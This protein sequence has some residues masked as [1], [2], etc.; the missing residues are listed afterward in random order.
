[1]A[2]QAQ[3]TIDENSFGAGDQKE[4]SGGAAPC[5]DVNLR[6]SYN[7]ADGVP[8]VASTVTEAVV[9]RT[10]TSWLHMSRSNSSDM[11]MPTYLVQLE[12]ST[13]PRISAWRFYIGEERHT[14]NHGKYFHLLVHFL[15]DRKE[16]L[17]RIRAESF[18][19]AAAE[20]R[21]D[22]KKAKCLAIKAFED[23][24]PATASLFSRPGDPVAAPE[25]AALVA[26]SADG[27]LGSTGVG[28]DVDDQHQTLTT[29]ESQQVLCDQ[30]CALIR[31]A[32]FEA[33]GPQE[34]ASLF[35][36]CA[37]AAEMMDA[38]QLAAPTS[39]EECGQQGTGE[40]EEMEEEEV[41]LELEDEDA[42]LDAEM[43]Q[44]QGQDQHQRASVCRQPGR[45]SY[46]SSVS[47]KRARTLRT[48]SSTNAFHMK[49]SLTRADLAVRK[50]VPTDTEELMRAIAD[51]DFGV[52]DS[53]L[54]MLATPAMTA[55]NRV[56]S[57]SER[58]THR[59]GKELPEEFQII[60]VHPPTCVSQVMNLSHLH[61]WQLMNLS[62][63][64][65]A[66]P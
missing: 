46:D 55:Y 22:E 33:D 58:V 10:V 12:S 31:A 13:C 59:R 20:M 23:A 50:S 53:R 15:P 32:V 41:E 34:L 36:A 45:L 7:Q 47:R 43:T 38:P 62:C 48:G 63:A 27:T 39:G 35:K 44:T 60:K 4:T 42:E 56:A 2:H 66:G 19:A 24:H 57:A 40:G 16:Q 14:L 30:A 51:Q 64:S 5:D 54:A 1:M 17:L 29:P 9:R 61:R 25:E 28:T 26:N 49:V 8:P 52:S 3:E 21:C 65:R 18:E 37:Q 6:I 11:L